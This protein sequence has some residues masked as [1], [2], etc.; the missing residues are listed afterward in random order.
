MRLEENAPLDIVGSIRKKVNKKLE[1]YWFSSSFL[2]CLS[3]IL[4]LL[5]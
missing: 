1:S 3:S 2:L 4:L 5:S